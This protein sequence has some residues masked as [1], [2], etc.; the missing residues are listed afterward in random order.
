MRS[1]SGWARNWAGSPLRNRPGQ[2]WPWQQARRRQGGAASSGSARVVAQLARSEAFYRDGLG[3]TGR[4]RGMGDPTLTATC[5]GLPGATTHEAVLRSGGQEVALVQFDPPGTANPRRD[6]AAATILAFQ[7]L[8][9]VVTLTCR[10]PTPSLCGQAPQP[11]SL[12]GP[13][14]LPP[15]QRRRVRLQVPRSG[16]PPARADPL[17]RGTGP[18]SMAPGGARA[19]PRHRSQRACCLGYVARSIRF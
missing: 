3:L 15:S 12:G 18:G 1:R 14:V 16:R 4:G 10:T 5:L 11:I 19:L 2:S 9:V 6:Q 7:H 17:P 13:Q 8:A